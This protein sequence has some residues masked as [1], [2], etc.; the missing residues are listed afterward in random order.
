ML[1][2]KYHTDF[3]DEIVQFREF[4]RN[5]DNKSARAMLQLIRKM[6][7]SSVFPNVDIALRIYL[8]LPVTN[9]S[10]ERSFSK[11]A[12]IKHRLR[13]T[14]GQDRLNHLTLMSLESDVLRAIDFTSLIKD[15]A[16]LKARKRPF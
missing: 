2:E 13:S 12:I 10:G 7:L 15:F 5:K 8:T 11:L 3:V 4:M 16:M 9:A 14:I 6:D 1:Q